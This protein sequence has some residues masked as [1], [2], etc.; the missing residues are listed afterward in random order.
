M[1]AI[2]K[3]FEP[4]GGYF[5]RGEVSYT[6][7]DDVKITSTGGSTVEASFEATVATLSIGKSF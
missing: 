3:N 7:Y 2:G 5:V 4:V 1:L 6:D